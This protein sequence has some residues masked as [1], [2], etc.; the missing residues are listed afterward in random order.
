MPASRLSQRIQTRSAPHPPP[1]QDLTYP[2]FDR[3]TGGPA[4]PGVGDGPGAERRVIAER[5]ND[6]ITPQWVRYWSRLPREWALSSLS[7][8]RQ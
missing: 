3:T 6:H 1:C 2:P 4:K 7:V 5:L 8:T